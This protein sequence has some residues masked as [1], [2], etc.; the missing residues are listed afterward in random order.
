MTKLFSATK[1]IKARASQRY[2]QRI[3]GACTVNGKIIW[4]VLVASPPT[5]CS[6]AARRPGGLRLAEAIP[7]SDTIGG[8]R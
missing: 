6:G 4:F 5:F 7:R 2:G 3:A 8:K 1:K